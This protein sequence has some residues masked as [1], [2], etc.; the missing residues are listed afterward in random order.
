[1]GTADETR[2]DLVQLTQLRIT[3]AARS[4]SRNRRHAAAA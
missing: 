3:L 2:L 4:R 1:L